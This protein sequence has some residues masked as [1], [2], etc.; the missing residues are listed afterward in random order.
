MSSIIRRKKLGP[1]D[2]NAYDGISTIEDVS[3]EIANN[4]HKAEFKADGGEQIYH[5]KST[6]EYEKLDWLE[7]WCGPGERVE[8]P[9]GRYRIFTDD[10]KPTRGAVN[11]YGKEKSRHKLGAVLTQKN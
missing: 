11:Y 4:S 3:V 8:L 10:G 9:H 7:F 1:V 6:R 2:P 5:F